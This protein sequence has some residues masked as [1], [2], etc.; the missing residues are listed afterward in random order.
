MGILY[1][2]YDTVLEGEV[3]VKVL[4]SGIVGGDVKPGCCAKHKQRLS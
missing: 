2:A 1:R 4:H 3:A